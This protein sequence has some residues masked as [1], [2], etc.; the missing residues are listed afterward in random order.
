MLNKDYEEYRFEQ[1]YDL[2][3]IAIRQ[4]NSSTYEESR[5]L[6]GVMLEIVENHL[7]KL[8]EVQTA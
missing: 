6:L 4:I 8:K 3:I 7:R 5:T 2:L 1:L